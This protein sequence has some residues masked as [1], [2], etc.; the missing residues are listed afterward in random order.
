MFCNYAPI[1]TPQKKSIKNPHFRQKIR[2][3]F[4]RPY[5]GGQ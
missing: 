3:N 5:P 2:R 1:E 4:P